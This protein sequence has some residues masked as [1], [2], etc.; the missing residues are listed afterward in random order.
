VQSKSVSRSFA[1]SNAYI[2]DS[3]SLVL[4]TATGRRI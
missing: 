1:T 4:K 3:P 2:Q